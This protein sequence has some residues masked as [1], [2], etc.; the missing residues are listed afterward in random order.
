MVDRMDVFFSVGTSALVAP[1]S[2]LAD[3]A[4]Q[5]GAV[6]V[7]INPETTDLTGHADFPL[8]GPAGVLLPALLAEL[9]AGGSQTPGP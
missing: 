1:A 9:D 2:S 7:E 6:I 3:A 5:A 8:A 4:R